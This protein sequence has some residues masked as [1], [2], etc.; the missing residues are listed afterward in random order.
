[1]RISIRDDGAGMSPE[2]LRRAFDPFFTTKAGASGAGLGLHVAR[3]IVEA[4]GGT[5]W[6]E[7]GPGAGATA[8]V[9]L[10]DAVDVTPPAT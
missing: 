1:M 5:V 8:I 10:P 3:G 2:V 6:L 7:S 9:E 4:Y